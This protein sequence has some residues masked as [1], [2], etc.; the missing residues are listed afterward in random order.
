MDL[1]KK[2]LKFY[3]DSQ[4]ALGYITN[5]ARRFYVYVANKVSRIRSFSEPDQWQ[6]V[7]TD[8]NPADLGT[9]SFDAQELS[10]SMWL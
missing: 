4:I 6:H 8:Q 10:Q 7:T 3:S 2:N 1:E 9:R 5:D